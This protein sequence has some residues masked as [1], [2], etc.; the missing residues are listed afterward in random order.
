MIFLVGCAQTQTPTQ[1]CGANYSLEGLRNG[2]HSSV[3][4]PF[5]PEAFVERYGMN[6]WSKVSSMYQ[7]GDEIYEAWFGDAFRESTVYVFRDGCAVFG[8]CGTES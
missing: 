2:R 7:E 1:D 3:V 4:G 8:C 5:S 6:Q